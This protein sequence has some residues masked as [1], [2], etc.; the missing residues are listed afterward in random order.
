MGPKKKKGKEKKA[1]EE[2]VVEES[3]KWADICMFDSQ[4][5]GP[6]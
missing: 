2:A 4:T 6:N 1:A 5:N 3:G